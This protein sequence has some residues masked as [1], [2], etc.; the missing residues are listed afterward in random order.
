[1]VKCNECIEYFGCPAIEPIKE[2]G[3]IKYR[4]DES[5]CTP[6]ICPGVCKQICFNNMIRKTEI[7]KND[8]LT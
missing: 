4:I 1:M 3:D 2:D 8:N 6:Y 7:Y 5:L